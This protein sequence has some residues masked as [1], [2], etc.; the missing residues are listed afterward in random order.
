MG[1]D[2]NAARC[3]CHQP[4]SIRR[5][6]LTGGLALAV[7]PFGLVCKNSFAQVS[8]GT[9]PQPGDH[10]AFMAGD[11]KD[12]EI[13]PADMIVGAAPTLAYPLDV[14]AGK[15]LASRA[16]LLTL[17]R[18]KPEELK[19]S[20]KKNAADGIVAFS[21]VCTHYGCPVTTLHP[22][23]TQI[24]CNCHGSVFDIA[25]HGIVSHGPATRRLAMLPLTIKDGA[26]VVAGQLDGPIGPPA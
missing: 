2:Q 26:L 9:K 21:A 1:K 5:S 12:Q 4:N 7:T 24:V 23:Q 22:S 8:R 18:L 6:L 11:R 16:G 15:V 13:K 10:L 19:P 20:S 25:D 3:P 14:A 17:A